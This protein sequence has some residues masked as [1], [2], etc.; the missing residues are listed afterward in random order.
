MEKKKWG[1][2]KYFGLFWAVLII[3][4]LFRKDDASEGNKS[5]DLATANINQ[6]YSSDA[7]LSSL[8][9]I[10][11]IMSKYTNLQRDEAEKEIKGAIVQWT[12][13]VYEVRRINEKHY[14]IQTS[15]KRGLVG[16]FIHIRNPNP[17]DMESLLRLKTGDSLTVKGKIT[18]VSLRNIEIDPAMIVK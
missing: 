17:E 8:S 4:A 14:K 1:F 6:K 5:S 12:L 3:I 18:G 11:G 13:P 10:F 2:W 7:A 16:T 15:S 9:E